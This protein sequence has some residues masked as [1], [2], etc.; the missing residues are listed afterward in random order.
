[1][2]ILPTA[3]KKSF[4]ALPIHECLNILETSREGLSEEEAKKRTLVFGK[5]SIPEKSKTTKTKILINQLKS[6]LIFILFIAGI[7]TLALQKYNDAAFIF[8]AAFINCFLSFYQ[9]NKAEAALS[10]LKTY[11]EKR[12]RVLREDH[13]YE[14]DAEE[15]VPGD[16]IHISQG[17]RIPCDARLIYTNNFSVDESTLTGESLPVQ[18]ITD[19]VNFQAVLGDQKC[20]IFAGTL[21][22]QGFGNAIVTTTGKE[23]EIGKIALLV[24]SQESITPLQ[25]TITNFSL[26]ASIF[27]TAATAI[28]FGIGVYLGKSV[29][30]MFLTSVAVLVAA[31]PEGL[32]VAM[33]AI[34]AIGVQRLV[35][36]NGVVRKLLAAEVLGNTTIILTDK[37]GTLTEAKMTLSKIQTFNKNFTENEILK[38]ALLNTD[39]VIE[40]PHEK[41]EKWKIIGRPLEVATVKAAAYNGIFL[42][43]EKREVKIN[44]FLPFSSSNKFSAAAIEYK[45]EEL[46]TFFGAP[47]ILLKISDKS[48]EEIKSINLEINKL[49]YG[50][51]RVLG[52]AVKKITRNKN[53][54]SLFTEKFSELD[55]AGIISF[56][57]PIRKGVKETVHN[58]EQ[59]GIKTIIITGD[60]Q[61]TAEAIAQELGFNIRKESVINGP[62]LDYIS[63]SELQRRLPNLKIVSRVSPEGKLRIVKAFQEKGEIVAMTGD[64]INDA[65][66]LKQ[67]DIGIAMGS[68]SDVAK[69]TSE[70]ILL[71]DNYETIVAAIEEGRRIIEN[72]RK[73]IVYV[74]L[75][76]LDELLLIGGSLL[77]GLALPINA[78]QILWIN[79]FSDSFPA[80]AF[81]FENHFNYLLQKP[82]HGQEKLINKESRFL[83]LAIGLTTSFSLIIIYYLL[84]KFGFNQ[85][86][87]RTFI[88]ASFGT[89]SLFSVFSI[90]NLKE[91][92]FKYN[93]FSNIYLDGGILIGFVLMSLAIYHPF[94]QRLMDTVNL[95]LNWL[96][97]VLG[98]GII[99][100]VLLEIGKFIN[101]KRL[102][103]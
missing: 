4:W 5:N 9:E 82:K 18:K 102:E 77:L 100:I 56:K 95:P 70:L 93:P 34:L 29:F 19:P 88:F 54:I 41:I 31:I 47:D 45:N 83:I 43:K 96:L 76:L 61:G 69:D 24:G 89:Y 46:I 99:N 62:E 42:N 57:D 40:N 90:R 38:I 94:L 78:F 6:P 36:K 52:V 65:P 16:M 14:I 22:V 75:S 81:A 85:E 84:I 86:I 73:T 30:D 13:E 12:A 10:H 37:T 33:T 74:F 35:K 23:T 80:I 51:E 64:G 44:D 2:P 49:A 63:D 66:S 87:S 60:H 3:T 21:A 58:I 48:P 67:A 17:E 103:D 1:M 59:V 98:I 92:L 11:I 68:G 79:F 55:F 20:M 32:P 26:K 101:N 72:I 15:L 71:D 53:K 50:G 8:G 91:S 39:V 27:L 97:G 28:M 7:I 25:K